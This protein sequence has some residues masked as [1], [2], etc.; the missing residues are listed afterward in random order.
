M[1]EYNIQYHANVQFQPFTLEH[2][3]YINIGLF[4]SDGKIYINKGYL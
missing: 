4:G 3:T 1:N 2:G